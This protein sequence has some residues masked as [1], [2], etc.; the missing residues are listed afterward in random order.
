MVEAVGRAR[1][2]AVVAHGEQ[3][4]GDQPYSVHLDAVAELLA[5][6]GDV[7]QV[8]GYL[9]DVVEDTDVPLDTVRQG[10]GD[11]VA[12]CVSLVTDEPGANRRERK[13][14][15]NAKLSTVSGEESLAL[16]VK[17]AD[18]LAN[19]RASA[20]NDSGSKL[21]MYRREHPAFRESAYRPGLCDSLWREMDRILSDEA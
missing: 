19:L 17:A 11:R 5:P 4:Y 1:A 16:V 18:R 9:H 8:I 6:F 14:K 3:R 21:G 2:F 12:A 20:S 10:F 15:T 7:A 13:A